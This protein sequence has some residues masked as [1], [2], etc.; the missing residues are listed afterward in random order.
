MCPVRTPCGAETTFAACP[1]RWPDARYGGEGALHPLHRDARQHMAVL[2]YLNLRSF[3][4]HEVKI[5][6]LP[7]YLPQIRFKRALKGHL[8]DEIYGIRAKGVI[9]KRHIRSA[10]E[11]RRE[12][13]L[14]DTQLLVVLLFD[15]DQIIE[16]LHEDPRRVT[17]LA[18]AGYDLV[19]SASFSVWKP[20]PRLHT[21][22]NLWRSVDL[23]VALQEMGAPAIPRLDWQIEHD[24]E[25]W[26]EWIE[27]NPS[28]H[29]VAIDAMTCET[30]GWDEVL[31]GLALLDEG[32]DQRLHYLVNGPSVESRW[33]EL[34]SIVGAERLTLT[35]AGPIAAPPTQQEKLEF[36]R[37]WSTACGPRYKA[38]ILKRRA[39]VAETAARAA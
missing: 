33:A 35:E 9:G 24:V 32:T 5:P 18:A 3:K 21:L 4:A 8:L 25:R 36:G 39:A 2:D 7:P 11:I 20:R 16:R 15:E 12:L 27:M 6:K 28:I 13:G 31:E 34:F 17:A 14:S 10:D 37:S 38:R 26:I 22:R 29:M 23:C 30:N 19:V 1:L